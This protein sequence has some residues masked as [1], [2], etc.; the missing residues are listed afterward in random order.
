MELIINA[1]FEVVE[2]EENKEY[3]KFLQPINVKI[4]SGK[5]DNAEECYR[6]IHRLCME[7]CDNFS[8][9]E[10]HYKYSWCDEKFVNNDKEI[11]Q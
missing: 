7:I 1:K 5:H 4:A 10:L 6:N 8:D 3:Y 11:R 9:T 2:T